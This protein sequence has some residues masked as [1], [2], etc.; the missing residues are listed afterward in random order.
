MELSQLHVSAP[1]VSHAKTAAA[2][3]A[4]ARW[5]IARQ[6]PTGWWCGELEADSTLESYLVLLRAFT[7]SPEHPDVRGLARTIR[8]QMLPD[9]GWNTY[10]G[11]PAELSAS[12][13]SYFALKIAGV[14]ASDDDMRRSC[15][16]IRNLG[17]AAGANSYTRYH[18]AM[19]GQLPW[20]EVPAIPPEM[21]LL[22]ARAPFSVYDLSSWSRTIFVPLSIVWAVKPVRVLPRGCGIE[23]LFV[24]S[25]DASAGGSGRPARWSGASAFLT[26]DNLMKAA[27]NIPFPW[28]RRLAVAR[29]LGWITQRLDGSDGLGAI[30]PAMM[31]SVV[32]LLCTGRGVNDPLVRQ[33]I[34]QLEA[35]QLRD[36]SGERIRVQPCLSPVWDTCLAVHALVQ[37]GLPADAEPLARAASWLLSRQ[38]RR[39]GDWSWRNP[40]EPGGWAFEH[41]NEPYPDVDDTAMALMAL[42]GARTTG[43]A[44][45]QRA[46][47]ERGLRWMLGMQNRDGGFAS[48]DRGNDKRWLT[49]VPF[50]DHNAMIDPS[51]ADITG[52]VLECLSHFPGFDADHPVVK[53]AVHFLKNDQGLDGSWYGRWGVNHIYGTW[54]VLKGL[55]AMGVP[56]AQP[57]I[58]RAA[59][60]LNRHQNADGGWGES[61]ASYD[62]VRNKGKGAST[63]SQ[64]AWA[65]MG[66]IAAGQADADAVQR[67]VRFLLD[68]QTA[69]GTWEQREWTGTGFPGVFYLNY[70]LYR[71]Y[72]PLMALAQFAA[73]L[74]QTSP[75]QFEVED[76]GRNHEGD[77]S[78]VVAQSGGESAAVAQGQHRGLVEAVPKPA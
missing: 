67:G 69:D 20:N 45:L 51:T 50:A 49:M 1:R 4:A 39:R 15:D 21:I 36:P 72:F 16:V 31:S 43:P 18:L 70:H 42:H 57:F 38:T 78:A 29:S 46:A 13:L 59:G 47:M 41:R 7:G 55:H 24:A 19:F 6:H 54:Q 17:G 27:E 14:P 61:I 68:R 11:G 33:G 53:R 77:R 3:D 9:G 25:A 66:L 28:V 26:L 35:L 48:F 32:A 5:L 23:E 56:K 62:D 2:I 60:W 12:C 75:R 73:T 8:D 63:V 44:E 37:A 74:P 71:H 58:R 76:V 65:V 40:A 64:T 30:L 34:E 52:R 10:P 22:P